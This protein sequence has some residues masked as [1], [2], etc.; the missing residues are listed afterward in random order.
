M[1][2]SFY[3]KLLIAFLIGVFYTLHISACRY[4]VREIGFSDIGSMPYLIYVY[5]KSD[6]PED[7]ISKIKKLSFALHYETNV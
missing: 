6:M 1:N 2:R 7:Y 5:T 4:T 3:L